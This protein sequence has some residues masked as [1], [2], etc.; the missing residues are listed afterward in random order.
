MARRL[1]AGGDVGG[2]RIQ[3]RVG[4]EHL[5]DTQVELVLGEPTLH[6][7]GLERVEHLLTADVRRRQ[8]AI[9]LYVPAAILPPGWPTALALFWAI[10][11]SV[12][13]S[14]LSARPPWLCDP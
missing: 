9:A 11:E 10:Y 13:L 7:R 1:S 3:F 14:G 5:A 6:E 8:V 4:R 12:A 2:D